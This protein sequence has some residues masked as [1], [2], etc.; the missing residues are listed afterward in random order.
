MEDT[1]D[2]EVH[3]I[4]LDNYRVWKRNS[5]VLYDLC[6]THVLEYPSLSISFNNTA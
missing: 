3:E 5:L 4:D 1:S 2:S 6:I